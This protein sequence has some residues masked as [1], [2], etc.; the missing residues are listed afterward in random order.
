MNDDEPIDLSALIRAL[1]PVR[2]EKCDSPIEDDFLWHYMKVAN[3][4]VT[5]GRQHECK[6]DLGLFR[7][8]FVVTD[9]GGTMK[10]GVEC[11]GRDF[12]DAARDAKRDEA[13]IRAGVLNKIYRIPGSAL[14]HCIYD[15]LQLLAIAE[16]WMFS[17][18]GVEQLETRAS[19]PHEHEDTWGIMGGTKQGGVMRQFREP[20]EDLDEEETVSRRAVIITWTPCS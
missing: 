11:D 10:I 2:F 15:A 17:D 6:T 19:P 20:P 16:P 9:S 7:V 13:I 3:E 8:D 14:Y 18:R 1:G 12:H 4:S 5:F